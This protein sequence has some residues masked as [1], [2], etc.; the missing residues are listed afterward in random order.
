MNYNKILKRHDGMLKFYAYI[1]YPKPKEEDAR[2][3]FK[4][5]LSIALW[6]YIEKKYNPEIGE[7]DNFIRGNIKYLALQLITK[8]RRDKQTKFENSFVPIEDCFYRLV[9]ETRQSNLSEVIETR[10]TDIQKKIV[11]AIDFKMMGKNM[12]YASIANSLN[13]RPRMFSY[14]LSQIR[15]IMRKYVRY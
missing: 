15:D 4:Q 5:Q 9:D 1:H 6:Q 10:L 11:Y 12:S 14:Y 7:I 13:M 3:E 2:D 8:I